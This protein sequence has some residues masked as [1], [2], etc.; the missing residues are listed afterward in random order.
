MTQP[1]MPPQRV[2]PSDM[3]IAELVAEAKLILRE[4][5]VVND[6]IAEALREDADHA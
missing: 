3:T 2:R 5:N 1:Q 6:Q 4:L